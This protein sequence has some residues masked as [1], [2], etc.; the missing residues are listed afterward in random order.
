MVDT[1]VINSTTPPEDPNHAEAMAAKFDAAQVPPEGD[2]PP[3]DDTKVE[4]RPQWLPEKFKSPED[5]AKAYAELESKL[6]KPADAP[7]DPTAEPKADSQTDQQ[8]AE[9]LAS[10]GLDLNEFNAEFGQTGQLSQESYNKLEKA[11]YPRNIVDQYIDGQRARAALYESEIKNVAG[12]D[13]TFSEMVEWAKA[14]LSPA[15]INAYNAAI[16]SGDTAK[17]KLAVAGVHTRFSASRP[18]EPN[19]FKGA[20][21]ATPSNESYESLAQMQKDMASPEYKSDPAFRAKVERKL[22]NSSIM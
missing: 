8:A 20:T 6:G 3:T 2:N 1:V 13:Q 14:N 15:E 17:A 18:S 19:L 21:S 7:A 9:E 12:G 4:D 5:M 16:D 11:G 10:K 22:A